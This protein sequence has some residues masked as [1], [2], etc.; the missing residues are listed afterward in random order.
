MRDAYDSLSEKDVR[1]ILK[2]GGDRAKGMAS[3][4]MK[5]IRKK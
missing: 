3:V 5:D 2:D 1:Q 4:K